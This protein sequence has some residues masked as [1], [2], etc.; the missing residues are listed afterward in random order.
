MPRDLSHKSF[1]AMAE[2]Q[3]F[4]YTT[5]NGLGAWL[6]D[7]RSGDD[8]LYGCVFDLKYNLLRRVSLAEAMH[9]RSKYQKRKA[10]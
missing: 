8:T 1:I 10:K 5:M 4:S 2:R 9:G 7:V 6:K 3:G